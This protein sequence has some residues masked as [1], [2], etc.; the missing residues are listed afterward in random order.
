[1]AVDLEELQKENKKKVVY[2]VGAIS[3]DIDNY[4]KKFAQ[5]EEDLRYAGFEMIIN[6]TCL[7]DNLPYRNY[8]PISIAFVEACDVV[9]VLNDWRKSTGAMAEVAYA[10]MAGKEIIY[11][12]ERDE[13]K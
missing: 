7:P 5:T 9:Y 13:R 3:L 6:P 11:Q 10:K 8:A 12:E 4:K 1:M 2:I